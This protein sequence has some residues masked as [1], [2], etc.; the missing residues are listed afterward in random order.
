MM[1]SVS[2]DQSDGSFARHFAA[3]IIL[4][5]YKTHMSRLPGAPVLITH[6]DCSSIKA[7]VD[8]GL[9]YVYYFDRNN[10]IIIYLMITA[11]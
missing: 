4:L 5:L 8:G 2:K 6:W 1:K 11:T 10:I 3:G 7:C 9:L